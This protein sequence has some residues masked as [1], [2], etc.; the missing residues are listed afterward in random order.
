MLAQLTHGGAA[1]RNGL[2][3]VLTACRPGRWSSWVRCRFSCCKRTAGRGA[4]GLPARDDTGRPGHRGGAPTVFGEHAR[5][6]VWLVGIF[7]GAG[8]LGVGTVVLAR[9]PLLHDDQLRGRRGGQPCEPR[10]QLSTSTRLRGGHRRVGL[11]GCS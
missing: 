4:S 1:D 2:G 5:G 10:K 6:G 8:L 9:S 7:L 11:R 3:E